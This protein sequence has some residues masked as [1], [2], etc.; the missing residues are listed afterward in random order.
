MLE[1]SLF[2]LTN[3]DYT[4]HL[5]RLVD[6][7]CV[8]SDG[9]IKHGTGR[10]SNNTSIPSHGLGSTDAGSKIES[11]FTAL[12]K[13]QPILLIDLRYI[14]TR[15]EENSRYATYVYEKIYPLDTVSLYFQIMLYIIKVYV[16]IHLTRFNVFQYNLLVYIFR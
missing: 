5:K 4:L 16:P 10:L 2:T 1:N 11:S 15:Q 13:Q 14:N 12:P 9:Y 8:I 7:K 3:T 6:P